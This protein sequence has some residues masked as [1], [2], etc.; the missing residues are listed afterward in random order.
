MNSDNFQIEFFE[1]ILKKFARRSDG[2]EAIK[3]VLNREKD[4]VYRRINGQAV[5][6]AEE[7]ALLARHF[8]ISVD[9]LVHRGSDRISVT[10]PALA[11][12]IQNSGD[13]LD[14]INASIS[15]VAG[16]KN[17]SGYRAALG[18]PTYLYCLFP[19]LLAFRMY[20]FGV[21]GWND[22]SYKDNLF[23]FDLLSPEQIQKATRFAQSYIDITTKELWNLSFIDNAQ[24][25]IE[26]LLS[27]DKFRRK[28]D[29]LL[30]C[31]DMYAL[32]RHARRMAELGK[33]FIPGREAEARNEQNFDLY[34]N[35]LPSSDELI[36]VDSLT[37]Q[38]VFSTICGPNVMISD[39]PHFAA[40]IQRW[41][42]RILGQSSSISIYSA[43][44][45]N[46]FFNLLEHKLSL[47]RQRI[48]NQINNGG[49]NFR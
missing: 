42:Q 2:I 26:F 18:P 19:R 36:Y 20:I 16:L 12:P 13:W 48:E 31:D 1:A 44:M 40:F 35:E 38:L 3:K 27:M 34:Y 6:T 7:T 8:N 10:V 28:E 25:P 32:L 4:P 23:S 29:A 24:F 46:Q 9:A 30:L 11:T 39:D 49:A 5:L 22:R 33:K 47:S 17:A 21:T 37:S 14:F 45:R 43:K 15:R 41:F